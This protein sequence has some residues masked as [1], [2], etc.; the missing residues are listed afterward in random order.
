MSGVLG[1][2]SKLILCAVM[3]RGR[4][5]GLPDAID[6]SVLLPDE[7]HRQSI[8]EMEFREKQEAIRNA[9]QQVR[10]AIDRPL[11]EYGHETVEDCPGLP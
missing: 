2:C 5:R 11:E 4:H 10:T 1:T 6:R 9:L 3:L 7:L 8:M